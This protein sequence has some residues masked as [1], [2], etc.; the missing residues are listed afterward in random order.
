MPLA[1]LGPE[2]AA[3]IGAG[4]RVVT[5]TDDAVLAAS[6]R[7]PVAVWR[8]VETITERFTM[9]GRE[10]DNTL[11]YVLDQGDDT[12]LFVRMVRTA[13]DANLA[14][15]DTSIEPADGIDALFADATDIIDRRASA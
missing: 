11:I 12:Y 6:Q 10:G 13:P 7:L 3:M 8:Q 1:I 2:E 14:I 4:N 5:L 9:R 15:R